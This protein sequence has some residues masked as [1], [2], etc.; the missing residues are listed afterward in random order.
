MSNNLPRTSLPRLLFQLKYFEIS[1]ARRAPPNLELTFVDISYLTRLAYEKGGAAQGAAMTKA[2]SISLQSLFCIIPSPAH[3]I[4]PCHGPEDLDSIFGRPGTAFTSPFRSQLQSNYTGVSVG[5]SRAAA[6]TTGK[7][8]ISSGNSLLAVVHVQRRCIEFPRPL[9]QHY[10]SASTHH[11][12][13]PKTTCEFPAIAI[14]PTPPSLPTSRHCSC[15]ET[16]YPNPAIAIAPCKPR[17][18]VT[19]PGI[20]VDLPVRS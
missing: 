1:A 15:P 7:I 10:P 20:A 17:D 9:S 14:A 5:R 2:S 18:D 12:E 3:Q 11:L 8:V 19:E 6:T 13:C 16:T 4:H